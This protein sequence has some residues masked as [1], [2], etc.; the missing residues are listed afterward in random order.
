MGIVAGFITM[1]VLV[2]AVMAKPCNL[3]L[4]ILGMSIVHSRIFLADIIGHVLLHLP[5]VV[6][7][8]P[9]S[10]VTTLTQV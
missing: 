5:H 1:I 6:L 8:L 3:P 4:F 9:T 10:S 7:H 2:E